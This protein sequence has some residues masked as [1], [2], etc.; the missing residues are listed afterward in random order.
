MNVRRGL[1]ICRGWCAAAAL[2]LL[3]LGG[4]GS[5]SPAHRTGRT[6]DCSTSAAKAS[7]LPGYPARPVGVPGQ[8]TSVL[9][10]SGGWAFASLISFTQG[11]A[12]EVL[13]LVDGVPRPVRTV[14]V[15]PLE[16]AFG[17]T[18]T[19]DGRL[20]L[21]AG[22]NATAVLDVSALESGRRNPL[23]GVLSDSGAGQF[24]VAVSADDR[25]A[26]VS[27][28]NT[29]GVSVFDLA[30]ALRHGFRATGVATGIVRLAAGPVGLAFA[31][32]GKTLY[33]TTLGA[34]G[35]HGLVWAI[36]VARAERAG[37]ASAVIASA[38][39]GCQPVRVAVSPNGS[40]VWVTA[41]QSDALLGFGARALLDHARAALQAVVPVGSEPVGLALIDDGRLALVA[42]SNRGLVRGSTGENRPQTIS[43]VD[44]KAALADRPALRGALPAGLFPRDLNVDPTAREVLVGN[45][46]S[47]TIEALR[48]PAAP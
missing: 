26:F 40:V 37:S 7:L 44:T 46:N 13:K 15:A 29:G 9:A 36:D 22:Y 38:P 5:E 33:A 1:T 14:P 25:Y 34:A 41:L 24:E 12:V 2:G 28:E 6:V 39:A 43:V 32:D 8:P 27:D 19:H 11:A 42:N 23:R 10:A 47:D 48:E 16:D 18:L 45:F 30:R 20:L 21:V 3:A 4:C 35:E 31:P 17:M